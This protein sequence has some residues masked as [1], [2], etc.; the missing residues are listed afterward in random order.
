MVEG[1]R[2]EEDFL[3][4]RARAEADAEARNKTALDAAI[5]GALSRLEGSGRKPD[6]VV[7]IKKRA[8]FGGANGRSRLARAKA[9]FIGVVDLGTDS[10]GSHTMTFALG[11][12]GRLYTGYWYPE[13]RA[14]RTSVMNAIS[15]GPVSRRNGHQ[16]LG[17]EGLVQLL[18]AVI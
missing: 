15:K 2:S 18:D 10:Y 8:L 14:L 12:D 9:W 7:E 5:A 17:G 13:R 6:C 11:T 16:P 3:R 1:Y 4:D